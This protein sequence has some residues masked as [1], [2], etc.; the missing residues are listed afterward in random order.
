MAALRFLIADDHAA[1]RRSVRSLLESHPRWTVCCEATNGR[2]AV[3]QVTQFAPDVVLLDMTMPE[4]DGFEATR[5]IL[6]NSPGANVFILTMHQ[7]EEFAEEVRRTGARGMILKSNAEEALAEAIDSIRG[8][9]IH[10]AGSVVG[11]F[12][13]IGAFFHSKDEQ[14]R[15]LDPF[16]AEGLRQG[17]KE[18]HVIE[19][20]SRDLHVSRLQDAG[21]DINQATESGQIELIPWEAMYLI[22]G[23]FD[24]DAMAKRIQQALGAASEQGYA[25]TRLVGHMEW[26][27][28]D[29]PGVRDLA[30]YEARL[31]HVLP[32]FEDV[33]V[34]AYDLT[35]FSSGVTIDVLRSHP[36]VVIG[37]TLQNNPFYVQPSQLIAELQQRE[38]VD[39]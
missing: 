1:V 29:R 32:N 12:R 4:L 36:A 33:I 17:D 25:R 35:R 16:F 37:E 6:K 27:L 7:S 30:E 8:G 5:Q 20:P 34:C 14:H 26:A 15:V 3:E 31:N 2:E 13:H 39:H 11:R 9:T 10:L 28:E 19:P 22:D 18:V 38:S 23:H 24:Q 21:V